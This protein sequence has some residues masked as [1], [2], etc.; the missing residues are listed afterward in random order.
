MP[1]LNSFG[2]R[3]C[4]GGRSRRASTCMPLSYEETT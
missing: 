2:R 4:R 1:R 3:R